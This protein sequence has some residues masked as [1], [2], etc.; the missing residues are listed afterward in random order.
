MKKRRTKLRKFLIRTLLFLLLLLGL[1]GVLSRSK[2]VQTYFAKKVATWLSKELGVKVKIGSVEFDFFRN[3]HLE[4]VFLGDRNKD[5]LISAKSIHLE[6]VK[7]DG[8]NR[9]VLFDN[10]LLKNTY[11]NIGYHKNTEDKN[12][13]FLL[14]YINGPK[15]P[16]TGPP[17]LW[18]IRFAQ[19][20]LR[21]CEF[22]YFDD[23][24]KTTEKG[25]L[26]QNN[27]R[28]RKLNGI[29]EE[30]NIVDDSLHFTA[31]NLRTN[32]RSGMKIKRM[33][34]HCNIHYKGMDFTKMDVQLGCS[35]L[36]GELHFKYPG[37]K[38]LDEFV[39]NTQWKGSFTNS[40]ICLGDLSIFTE[41]LNGHTENFQVNKLKVMGTFDHI[42]LYQA[43]LIYGKKSR[44]QGEFYMAGLP[45]WRTTICDFEI[46]KLNTNAKDLESLFMGAKMPVQLHDAG[47]MLASGKFKG[48][49]LNFEWNGSLESALGN[50]T[51]DVA[52]NLESG[53][54][55]AEYSGRIM[56]D[57]FDLSKFS[58]DLGVTAL[59]IT[60]DGKG[61]TEAN[62]KS[63]MDARLTHFTLFGRNFK[64]GIIM[65]DLTASHF[66]GKAVLNDL[67]V[68]SEF[69]GKIEFNSE[70]P[71]F[72]FRAS[73]NGLDLYEIGL[74]SV[75]TLV[76]GKARV[77][78]SGMSLD[79]FEGRISLQDVNIHRLGEV[80]D[81]RYQ[82]I[83]KTGKKESVIILDGNLVSGN[84]RGD[85]SVSNIDAIVV[86]SMA[87][88]FPGRLVA[89]KDYHGNDDFQFDITLKEPAI[90]Y[91]Y[92][93]PGMKT[94]A[95]VFKGNY[96]YSERSGH[97]DV[98]P[99]DLQYGDYLINKVEFHAGLSK[100][101]GLHVE[102]AA[103]S[104]ENTGEILLRNF[105]ISGDVL[106]GL[107]EYNLKLSDKTGKYLVDLD[108]ISN[109]LK[110]SFTVSFTASDIK[111]DKEDWKI[112]PESKLV[113][114]DNAILRVPYLYLD[115]K[116]HFVEARGT[117]SKSQKDTLNLDLG[118]FGFDFIR[119]FMKKS[120]LDSLE[121]K[122]NGTVQI[123]GVF[124][125][126]GFSGGISGR[127]IRFY[128]VKYGDMDI[129]INNIIG[130]DRLSVSSRFLNGMLKG[131]ELSGNVRYMHVADPDAMN[132]LV[133]IPNGTGIQFLQPFLSDVLN[134][135]RGTVGGFVNI[136]GKFS[137]PE[138]TGNLK[139]KDA[140]AEVIYLGTSYH[141]DGNFELKK[142]GIFT[143]NPIYLYDENHTGVAKTK[144][145]ITHRNY[146]KYYMDLRIDSAVNLKCLNTTER[147]N[148]IYFGKAW[149]DGYC[150]IYGPLDKISMDI[151]LKSRKNSSVKLLYSDVEEN[152]IFG[153]ITF[154]DKN[155]GKKDSSIRTVNTNVLQKVN[156]TLELT[157]DLEAEFVIDKKLGDVIKGRG[158]G[159]LKMEYDE[160][161]NF[162]LYGTY[163]VS[164]GDYIFSLPGINLL[165]KKIALAPGGTI[166][167]SGDPYDANLN[168]SGSFEKKISPAAL[169]T[170][171]GNQKSYAPVKVKSTLYLTGSLLSPNIRF[172]IEAPELENTTA[173]SSNDVY[174]VIQRI[175]ADKDETMRQAVSI[176]LF[177]NFI[178]PAFAQ[179]SGT[180]V[181][182][183]SG[184]GIAGNSLSSIA[185]SVVN[186]IF[187]RLGIPTRIQ[188]NIDDVRNTK[189]STNT[190]LF[191]SSETFLTE[192]VRLDVNYDP[193]SASLLNNIAVPLNFKLEYQTRNENW[194]F[195]A[196]SRS[197][198]LLLQQSSTS[199]QTGVS[200]NT[201]GA[202][203]IYRKEFETFRRAKKVDST[204]S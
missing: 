60:M 154:G 1:T 105:G 128:S 31:K 78:A 91:N 143:E 64:D 197:S 95:I 84:I 193:T 136:N 34:A 3:I 88:I 48:K 53:F 67:R 151:R 101:T 127:D 86:N 186:D 93:M 176:L 190:Q 187:T 135:K 196:F 185:S 166:V 188:V 5:T 117:M 172:D 73:A 25:L 82:N 98:E 148:D 155:S 152:E 103:E 140:F 2:T 115:G 113:V 123:S 61:L 168:I 96:Q 131:L 80:F 167:W 145:S 165:T 202:G 137:A 200:G 132:L 85:L 125:N 106:Q 170:A 156:I 122:I 110:D 32:E 58:T 89:R 130:T 22:H 24:R 20:E 198:N 178:T 116:E 15:K 144:F 109:I 4:N 70:N 201:L 13:D 147:D 40:K 182:G 107:A 161:E 175:R 203:V 184:S 119:P 21:N 121:A 133:E 195:N 38:Y 181:G 87:E 163:R 194:R 192:R 23:E 102:T 16:K 71:K 142:N 134:W 162:Y 45:D 126:P 111:F 204:G 49:F 59:D 62:F 36:K 158:R 129:S 124:G 177:G 6:I 55:N 46:K 39:S 7:Y 76:W 47:D 10:L 108:A 28:F 18:T 159:V 139:V 44:V 8:T 14:D 19:A 81:Y 164:E 52:M 99:I 118:N 17:K 138:I 174:R 169:M 29:L 120:F 66:E 199:L 65:G 63:S 100:E 104:F 43:D 173:S 9:L 30:L 69:E 42:K 94:N 35:R 11:V 92:L 37:Y 171:V 141:F 191:V 57:N 68:N 75:H 97:L 114:L 150:H 33:D 50:A 12:I 157:P 189:G 153:F 72:D 41:D 74:D 149:A 146:E 27:L 26:D 54:E 112:D 179:S 90:F 77:D 56:T 160:N 180:S 183:I 79:E 51:T 83:S